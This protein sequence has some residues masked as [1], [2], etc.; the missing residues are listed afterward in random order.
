MGPVGTNSGS[1]GNSFDTSSGN[2]QGK[3]CHDSI[4]TDA[5]VETMCA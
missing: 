2:A 5:V 1:S 3:I 4:P